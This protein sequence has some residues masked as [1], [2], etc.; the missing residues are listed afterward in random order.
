MGALDDPTMTAKPL[1]TVSPASGD[2]MLDVPDAAFVPAAPLIIGLVGMQLVGPSAGAAR[3]AIAQGR[4]GVQRGGEPLAVVLVG[5]ADQHAKRRAV[6]V[7]DK[8]TLRAG[9]A[10]IGWVRPRR[11]APLFAGT[12]ALSSDALRQSIWPAPWRR[13]RS[14]R[15]KA[16]QT[17]AWCQS[18][19]RRQ[20]LIPEP[21][22]ISTG[23]ISQGRPDCST[24][25]M[26]VSTARS[27]NRG[28]PPFG[29]GRSAGNKGARAA[30][31]SSE[32][33]GLAMPQ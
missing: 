18:R 25:R 24:K 20:Q 26:P 3:P 12:E 32:T 15:C 7:D 16:V 10:A 13:S 8:V 19:K 27:G 4:N 28:R 23:S 14:T 22:P 5:G 33:R 2:A 9:P 11:A 1:A 21:Q 6:R 17:P 29:L 30:Q 31:R